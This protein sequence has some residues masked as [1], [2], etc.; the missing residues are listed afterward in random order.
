MVDAAPEAPQGTVALLFTDIE[1]ST[2]LA[3]AVGSKWAGVLA[4][5]HELVGGAISAEGGFI[6]GTEGDAFFATFQDAAAAARAAVA[7]LRALRTH[8]WPDAVGELKVRMGLHVGHVERRATGYVGLEVHRAARVAGAA[9]GGQLLL[10]A[11]ARGLVREALVV[12]PLGMHRLKDFPRPEELFCAVVDGRGAAAFP[13]PRVEQLRPTNL[14]AGLPMLVGRDF[15]LERVRS[16]LVGGGER[17]VTL[18]GRGGVGKTSLAL[19]AA[20][21]LLDEYPGGVWLVRL[22]SVSSAREVLVALASTIGAEG[23]SFDSPL[24]ALIAHLRARGRTLIVL[25]NMEHLLAAATDLATL[26]DALPDLRMLVTS[27]AS[28]RLAAEQRVPLDTLDDESALALMER[29]A[30]R[31]GAALTAEGS[32]RAALL[33]VAH[34]LDGLP[35]ALELA[36]AR[37][38]LLSPSQ[39]CERLRSSA[40][41]VKEGGGN[42]PERQRSL[43]AT[44]DWTLSLLEPGPREL[45]T[46][47]GAFAGPVELE[48]LE[49]VAGGDGLDVIEAL[50]GLLDVALVRRVESGDGRVRFG[51]PEALRQIAASR[52]DV[53]ADGQE[54][55]RAHARR[56]HDVA[57]AARTLLVSAGVFR[58][59]V[60]ADAEA[61]AALRWARARGDPLA[62]P[63]GAA[64]AMLLADTGR[65]REAL[66]VLEPLLARPS[67]EAAVDGLALAAHAI[68]LVVVDRMGE[69]MASAE[70]AVQI[71]LDAPA[72]ALAFVVRGLVH[73]YRGEAEA[74]VRDH[75][76]ATALAH[77]LG[78]AA[79]AGAMIYEAQARMCAGELDLAA[80]QLDEGGR[81]GAMADAKGLWFLD[82]LSG[83]LAL[84]SGRP[85][86]AFEHYAR[87][88]EAAQARGDQL[89]VFHDLEGVANALATVHD[90]TAALEV[91]GLAEA[92]GQDLGRPATAI[93]EH[94]VGYAVAD[95]EERV[96]AAV[97]ADR[98]ARGCAVSAGN[99]VTVACQLARARRPA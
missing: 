65:C 29:V 10:T 50:A 57:W 87:S 83:D 20:T 76:R 89:Q 86:G 1:G 75:E 90:D 66:A 51:L 73:L 74:S 37:L 81:I 14:P 39:L 58:T 69:A 40:D 71:S 21:D 19:R 77:S 5:H 42:R 44:V 82:T 4:D 33:E 88:L 93:G 6:D 94:L 45:F 67:G 92:H 22:A 59:A 12:E 13:P 8:D 25:D 52:L 38:G 7:A 16:A 64:R 79:L 2:R 43:R 78:P 48:E 60:S 96:G 11:A 84:L 70:R 24:H 46:R 97:A 17:L 53:A 47:M 80:E 3:R 72:R 98:R 54:W 55:R 9:H 62:A 27:Q 34:L 85:R 61:A 56:Q 31:R 15:D 95:A 32:N 23:A 36:A 41:V 28:L 63:L 30:R 99:R 35:L 91:A 18:T 68:T 49:A 26:L